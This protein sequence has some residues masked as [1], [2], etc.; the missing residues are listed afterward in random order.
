MNDSVEQAPV[1]SPSQAQAHETFETTTVATHQQQDDEQTS[2]A[3]DASAAKAQ[4]TIDD[5][6]QLPAPTAPKSLS[7]SR[8]LKSKG[9][10]LC[11]VLFDI[12]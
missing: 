10:T 6:R 12:R 3:V 8:T 1:R 9:T 7:P 11:L 2:R 4:T 5:K